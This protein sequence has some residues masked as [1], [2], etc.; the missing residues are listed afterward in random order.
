MVD[1]ASLMATERTNDNRLLDDLQG[2]HSYRWA[3]K[4]IAELGLKPEQVAHD[5]A[6]S[7]ADE[8]HSDMFLPILAERIPS[9]REAIVLQ[10]VRESLDLRELMYKG[11]TEAMER[12]S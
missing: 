7:K 2:G 9:D 1:V 5:V 12:V 4:W 6:H 11:I 8:K 10:A 3:N